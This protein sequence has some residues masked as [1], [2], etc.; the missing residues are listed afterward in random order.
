MSC[1][2]PDCTTTASNFNFWCA[3]SIIFSLYCLFSN[4]SIHMNRLRLADAMALSV[5]GL[6]VACGFQSESPQGHCICCLEVDAETAR[7]RT[8]EEAI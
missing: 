3:R 7:P 1:K 2:R 4:E 6:Q 5:H 8:E